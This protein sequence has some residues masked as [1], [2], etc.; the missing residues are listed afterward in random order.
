[1]TLTACD[2]SEDEVFEPVRATAEDVPADPAQ[3]D[4]TTGETIGTN[5]FTLYSLR[6]N[7]I[8]VS[9]DDAERADL[10]STRWDIG[11]NGTDIILNGG[12]SGP[13]AALGVVVP[14]AFD[15]VEDALA[16]DFTYRRDGESPCPD[17]RGP[18]GTEAGVP[19]AVCDGT[20][21][22][23]YTYVGFPSG[24]GGYVVPTAGR[25]LLVRLADGQG[26]AKVGFTSYY[27]GSPDPS[28]ITDQSQ[29]RYYSFEFVTNP[30]GSSFE[31]DMEM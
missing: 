3:R 1:M 19:R 2:S 11:F 5:N 20:G 17:V 27:Q 31:R 23:W 14:E 28:T 13:G 6:T 29:D 18:R 12:S 15:D 22:G 4:P 24:R 26:Y 7:E 21:N 9:Y 8:V 16:N 30:T 25:T 10:A